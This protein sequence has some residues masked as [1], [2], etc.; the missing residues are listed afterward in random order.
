MPTPQTIRYPRAHYC[1]LY[2]VQLSNLDWWDNG[3]AAGPGGPKMTLLHYFSKRMSYELLVGDF[4]CISTLVG[5]HCLL[6]QEA[7]L[8][9][10]D[11]VG[12][13]MGVHWGY[14]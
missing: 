5:K 6:W 3:G 10:P 2:G 7:H 12:D 11:H 4:Y 1:G 8:N 9:S 14:I 13:T